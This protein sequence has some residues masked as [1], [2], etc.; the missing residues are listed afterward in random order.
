METNK[1]FQHTPIYQR[2]VTPTATDMAGLGMLDISVDSPQVIS[3]NGIVRGKALYY[4]QPLH[5]AHELTTCGVRPYHQHPRRLQNLS[6]RRHNSETELPPNHTAPDEPSFLKSSSVS[7]TSPSLDPTTPTENDAS[8]LTA[9]RDRVELLQAE[10]ISIASHLVPLQLSPTASVSRNGTSALSTA[11]L[12]GTFTCS[13]SPDLHCRDSIRLVPC[14]A[15]VSKTYEERY[16][17]VL[18]ISENI[19]AMSL[20]IAGDNWVWQ[21]GDTD[22]ERELLNRVV[23]VSLERVPI[24]IIMLRFLAHAKHLMNVKRL[25][26]GSNGIESLSQVSSMCIILPISYYSNRVYFISFLMHPFLNLF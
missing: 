23:E 16:V 9:G 1:K 2:A 11:I 4:H 26:L 20:Q 6:P 8:E 21:W 19:S 14:T 22:S 5:E 10:Q 12:T 17:D 18:N 24:E 3:N 25:I 7:G 15:G 13:S